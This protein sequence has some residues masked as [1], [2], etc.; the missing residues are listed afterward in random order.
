M[1]GVKVK[2]SKNGK[3]DILVYFFKMERTNKPP[4][5][6]RDMRCSAWVDG[7]R[8]C[9]GGCADSIDS[10]DLENY[11]FLSGSCSACRV[12]VSVRCPGYM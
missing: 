1:M 10:L 11:G 5:E 4:C 12:P 8:C 6:E 7:I 9:A 2:G 3:E